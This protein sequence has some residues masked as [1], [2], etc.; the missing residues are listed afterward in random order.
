MQNANNSTTVPSSALPRNIPTSS[1]FSTW[2]FVRDWTCQSGGGTSTPKNILAVKNSQGS[3]LFSI[4]LG[5]CSNELNVN[6]LCGTTASPGG[7]ISTCSVSDFPLQKWVNVIVSL[8]GR[9]VDIF[10]D[11]KLVKTCVLDGVPKLSDTSQIILGGGFEG[12]LTNMKYK[13]DVIS[14]QEAWDIYSEGYGGSPFGDL[15]NKYK[16][17]LSFIVDNIEQTSVST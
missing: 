9:A 14:P 13:K 3:N 2:F 5:S 12:F 15:L 7:V 8:N 4:T 1:S 17:K 10:V 6:V 16:I 11:G